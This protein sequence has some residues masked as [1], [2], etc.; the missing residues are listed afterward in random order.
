LLTVESEQTLYPYKNNEVLLG[1]FSIFA[2]DFKIK[3]NQQKT[4]RSNATTIFTISFLMHFDE[5]DDNS[6]RFFRVLP[7]DFTAAEEAV[8]VSSALVSEFSVEDVVLRRLELLRLFI[9]F[10]MSS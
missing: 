7:S 1:I 4:H 9:S 8:M 3:S 5:V 10:S 6:C 2:F